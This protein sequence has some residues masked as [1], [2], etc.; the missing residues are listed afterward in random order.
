MKAV[1]ICLIMITLLVSIAGCSPE[2][3]E[4]MQSTVVPGTPNTATGTPTAPPSTT[5]ETP[6]SSPAT[7]SPTSNYT[8][9]Q[10][11]TPIVFT[12]DLAGLVVANSVFAFDLYQQL[13]STAK[14]NLFY[15]P[16][17]ISSALAMTCAGAR[18]ETA[19]QM[20]NTL[21]FSALGDSVHP[22][23]KDL[24]QQLD[25]ES[26][27]E[28]Y[29]GFSPEP[30]KQ[31]IEIF[32]LNIANAL[33]GQ[34]DYPFLA[35]YLDLVNRDYAGALKSLD[36]INAPEPSRLEINQW[37]SKKTEGRIPD[38]IPPG[39]INDFTRL[40]L[41]N[42][43]YFNARWQNEFLPEATHDDSFYLIDGTQIKVPMMPQ[44]HV[45]YQYGA[46]ENYQAVSL[47]YLQGAFSMVILLPAAGQFS[48]FAQSLDWPQYEAILKGMKNVEV[49]LTLPKF[50]YESSYDLGPTLSALGMPDAFSGQADFSGMTGNRELAISSVLHKAFIAVDEKGTEAAA[51]TAII[52][53]GAAPPATPVD[54]VINHPF[55]FLIQDNTSGAILFMGQVMNPGAH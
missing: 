1:Y 47:P 33:W 15:S 32:R 12:N 49:N 41:T 37:V 19:D 35:E 10:P 48:D 8:P 27:F 29:A 53:A 6:T 51:A 39:V 46:G 44:S 50:K 34:K 36:F 42:A 43:I 23:F 54:V 22:L 11:A 20:A 28:G 13:N 25:S 38:L 40:V 16:Y 2:T 55:I 7:A 24:S 17:S 9:T 52:M 45:H 14:G 21:H 5:H 31:T 3:T 18:G 4:T 30:T 26:K